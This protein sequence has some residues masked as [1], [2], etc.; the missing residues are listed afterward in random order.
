LKEER[1]RLA[2]Q[3]SDS[4]G[5]QGLL[6]DQ[7][8]LERLSRAL[9]SKLHPNIQDTTGLEIY[10]GYAILSTHSDSTFLQEFE[11]LPESLSDLFFPEV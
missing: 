3:W 8:L 7:Q 2:A 1:R 10:R 9:W 4:G 11:S 6:L 5:E